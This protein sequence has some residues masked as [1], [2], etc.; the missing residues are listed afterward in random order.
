M[1]IEQEK[2]DNFNKKDHPSV[3]NLKIIWH[4]VA[5]YVRSGYG[6]ITKNITS[7]L[8]ELG[9]DIIVSCYYGLEPGGVMMINDVPHLPVARHMGTFGEGS[10][11]KH[12]QSF[13]RNLGV[14]ASDW[15][16]FPWFP[17]K[18]RNSLLY[19]P[20]DHINYPEH[21][22]QLT[23][24]YTK[25]CA[26][27]PFQQKEL[28][29]NNIES[30]II[31]HGVDKVF[32]PMD[33]DKCREITGLS[34]DAFII[35]IVA[36]NSDKETRK[37]WGE[38]FQAAEYVKDNYPDIRD[39]RY[40]IHTDPEDPKGVSLKALAYHHKVYDL[41]AFEDPHLSVIGL[42]D[43]EMALLYNSFDILLSPSKREG[44]GLPI[45]ESMACGKPVIG[46]R[47]SSMPDLIGENEE[48]GWL[49]KTA[50]YLDTPIIATTGVPDYRSIAECIVDAYN[51][52]NKIE[53]K[54]KKAREF[55][56]DFLWDDI[57]LNKWVT[58]LDEV[59]DKISTKTEDVYRLE[60]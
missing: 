11:I 12:Y 32:R 37:A 34:K 20:M 49:C 27:L 42:P 19:S 35:G 43:E 5:A 51:H 16:A 57:I 7:R 4:S 38:I 6:N 26:F 36:A 28:A 55:S 8:H 1:F 21:I 39:I 40:F 58:V 29:K 56:L 33:K 9:Y 48:R 18:D 45:L 14:L 59:W 3:D 15:W 52:P 46:H 54:G 10:Y 2:L 23:K 31:P 25:V 44:F 53:E 47:F 41:C 30:T 50:L 22:V 17:S 24:Q 60:L 13:R